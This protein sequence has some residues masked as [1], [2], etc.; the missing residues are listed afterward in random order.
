MTL[1]AGI[2]GGATKTS[3]ALMDKDRNVLCQTMAGASNFNSVGDAAAAA[4]VWSAI[5]QALNTAGKTVKDCALR[6]L[7]CKMRLVLT[8]NRQW[9]LFVCA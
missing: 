8:A 1:Y 7:I 3:C 5:E 2:D 4:A 6:S 9:L